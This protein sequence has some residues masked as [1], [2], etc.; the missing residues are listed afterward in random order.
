M[1]ENERR[2]WNRLFQHSYKY[3]QEKN[4]RLVI[5]TSGV[6]QDVRCISD[7][8]LIDETNPLDPND[9]TDEEEEEEEN[10]DSCRINRDS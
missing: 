8:M 10:F 1:A 3:R 9:L 6:R 5:Q 7:R 2:D 4:E